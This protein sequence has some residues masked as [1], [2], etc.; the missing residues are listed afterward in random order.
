M[1]FLKQLFCVYFATVTVFP[2]QVWAQV[3]AQPPQAR[4]D[5]QEQKTSPA[6]PNTN[7]APAVAPAA[8][9]APAAKSAVK[10]EAKEGVKAGEKKDE[11]KKP[12]VKKP[13]IVRKD[14]QPL[15][16]A[17]HLAAWKVGAAARTRISS[18]VGLKF[19]EDFAYFQPYSHCQSPF[20]GEV[21]LS[22]VISALGE[23][24]TKF[25][26]FLAEREG[27]LNQQGYPTLGKRAKD[28][29][30]SNGHSCQP[31]FPNSLRLVNDENLPGEL[32]DKL[33]ADVYKAGSDLISPPMKA[34]LEIGDE[35][36]LSNRELLLYTELIDALRHYTGYLLTHA[37]NYFPEEGKLKLPDL[38][39]LTAVG[40]KIHF[41]NAR[42]PGELAYRNYKKGGLNRVRAVHAA[43]FLPRF[44]KCGDL[45]NLCGVSRDSS[46][47]ETSYCFCDSKPET[48]DQMDINILLALQPKDPKSLGKRPHKVYLEGMRKLGIKA[49]M[50]QLA[51]LNPQLPKES[52]FEL[53]QVCRAAPDLK[54]YVT[55]YN[56]LIEVAPREDWISNLKASV[57]DYGQKLRT[58]KIPF[59]IPSPVQFSSFYAKANDVAAI[60]F[61][62]LKAKHRM[63]PAGFAAVDQLMALLPFRDRLKD[64]DPSVGSDLA[65]HFG[66]KMLAWSYLVQSELSRLS[67]DQWNARHK[68]VSDMVREV[69]IYTFSDALYIYVS[70]LARNRLNSE[71]DQDVVLRAFW[72]SHAGL[73]WESYLR[74]QA[75]ENFFDAVDQDGTK[76]NLVQDIADVIL[77]HEAFNQPF[78][79][80]VKANEIAAARSR[81]LL[82]LAESAVVANEAVRYMS[83]HE[84]YQGFAATMLPGI[85][86][87]GVVNPWNWTNYFYAESK[88]KDVTEAPACFQVPDGEGHEGMYAALRLDP[89]RNYDPLTGLASP[90]HTGD[91]VHIKEGLKGI[92]G[93]KERVDSLTKQLEKKGFTNGMVRASFSMKV[94]QADGSIKDIRIE[95][96]NTLSRVIVKKMMETMDADPKKDRGIVQTSRAHAINQLR[97]WYLSNQSGARALYEKS[98]EAL[99]GIV[100]ERNLRAFLETKP[101]KGADEA[102]RK[103]WQAEFEKKLKATINNELIISKMDSDKISDLIA[104][105]DSYSDGEKEIEKLTKAVSEINDT[106]KS[107]LRQ[108]NA[109]D[110][111]EKWAKY[112]LTGEF[113]NSKGD[114]Q[115][116]LAWFDEITTDLLASQYLNY[117]FE[118]KAVKAT[119]DVIKGS[120][121]LPGFATYFGRSKKDSKDE[122]YTMAYEGQKTIDALKKAATPPGLDTLKKVTIDATERFV[123]K[124]KTNHRTVTLDGY[125]DSSVKTDLKKGPWLVITVDGKKNT[126]NPASLRFFLAPEKANNLFLTFWTAEGL[127]DDGK[128]IKGKW[129]DK[130]TAIRQ[131]SLVLPP[132][133]ALPLSPEG[134]KAKN[135]LDAALAAREGILRNAWL[136]EIPNENRLDFL[137]RSYVRRYQALHAQLK[138]VP[139]D[140]ELLA[141]LK[142][143][144]ESL[145][146]AKKNVSEPLKIN[147]NTHH[148]TY[149][150][151]EIKDWEQK[152]DE[153]LIELSKR[154][155]TK[156]NEKLDIPTILAGVDFHA[157]K[158]FKERKVFEMWRTRLNVVK[159]KVV[160]AI[161]SKDEAQITEVFPEVR[162]LFTYLPQYLLIGGRADAASEFTRKQFFPALATLLFP[163]YEEFIVE[164]QNRMAV[165]ELTDVTPHD[166]IK[167][168]NKDISEN[169]LGIW[170][171]EQK[172]YAFIGPLA[173]IEKYNDQ[174]LITEGHKKIAELKKR[175]AEAR[176]LRDTFDQL[177]RIL[178]NYLA[179]LELAQ[180]VREQLAEVVQPELW[181]AYFE[182]QFLYSRTD[183]WNKEP[184]KATVLGTKREVVFTPADV[185][186]DLNAIAKTR[187]PLVPV[188]PKVALEFVDDIDRVCK[189]ATSKPFIEAQSKLF[190]D[191]INKLMLDYY[192]LAAKRHRGTGEEKRLEQLGKRIDAIWSLQS[193]G[194]LASM[195]FQRWFAHTLEQFR[196]G[197]LEKPSLD[198]LKAPTLVEFCQA[199]TGVGATLR[200]RIENEKDAKELSK[201]VAY[202][203]WETLVL[204]ASEVWFGA[205]TELGPIYVFSETDPKKQVV[206]FTHGPVA[207]KTIG[208][209][210]T[211]FRSDEK[212]MSALG[213][214]FGQTGLSTA[215]IDEMLKEQKN[216][217]FKALKDAEAE[218]RVAALN[219]LSVSARGDLFEILKSYLQGILYAQQSRS[220]GGFSTRTK[221]SEGSSDDAFG[222]SGVSDEKDSDEKESADRPKAETEKTPAKAA[223]VKSAD[224]ATVQPKTAVPGPRPANGQAANAQKSATQPAAKPAGKTTG[225]PPQNQ[226]KT[227]AQT[228][229]KAADPKAAAQPAATTEQPGFST[230]VPGIEGSEGEAAPVLSQVP[231]YLTIFP[232]AKVGS[233]SYDSWLA[234][235]ET[236]IKLWND[237]SGT[238]AFLVNYRG[239][240]TSNGLVWLSDAIVTHFILHTSYEIRERRVVIPADDGRFTFGAYG[241]YD[242]PSKER[243]LD[244]FRTYQNAQRA[245]I[246]QDIINIV[247]Y[248]KKRLRDELE[249]LR[250][251]TEKER[252]ALGYKPNKDAKKVKPEEIKPFNVALTEAEDQSGKKTGRK[253]GSYVRFVPIPESKLENSEVALLNF[254]AR[255]FIESEEAFKALGVGASDEIKDDG[256]AVS[257]QEWSDYIAQN[258]FAQKDYYFLHSEESKI[259][260]WQWEPKGFEYEKSVSRP[261]FERWLSSLMA[262]P[263][264]AKIFVA[265]RKEKSIAPRLWDTF[266]SLEKFKNDKLYGQIAML[267]E[268]ADKQLEASKEPN[269]YAYFLA[270]LNWNI[271]RYGVRPDLKIGRQYLVLEEKHTAALM[272]EVVENL[273]LDL[274]HYAGWEWTLKSWGRTQ[275]WK[276]IALSKRNALVAVADRATLATQVEAPYVENP[277][278]GVNYGYRPTPVHPMERMLS[279]PFKSAAEYRQWLSNP[280]VYIQSRVNTDEIDR[281]LYQQMAALKGEMVGEWHL[282]NKNP[283]HRTL[284]KDGGYKF[285]ADGKNVPDARIKE[286]VK[287]AETLHIKASEPELRRV[288][289]IREAWLDFRRKTDELRKK[290]PF[291]S[292]RIAP[293]YHKGVTVPLVGW[294][295]PYVPS[296]SPGRG[297]SIA[298]NLGWAVSFEAIDELSQMLKDY[299][300]AVGGKL[301]PTINWSLWA[302]DY[303]LN[304]LFEANKMAEEAMY[305]GVDRKQTARLLNIIDKFYEEKGM[306][307][308][309][310]KGHRRIGENIVG[311]L[312]NLCKLD[313]SGIET[314]AQLNDAGDRLKK[315][316]LLYMDGLTDMLN[317]AIPEGESN[318][319]YRML[320]DIK[321]RKGPWERAWEHYGAPA[322]QIA[323]MA[324]MAYTIAGKSPVSRL[325]AGGAG[326]TILNIVFASSFMWEVHND[327]EETYG[328]GRDR[329]KMLTKI[330]DTRVTSYI[331]LMSDQTGILLFDDQQAN[332]DARASMKGWV[333]KVWL[334]LTACEMVGINYRNLRGGVDYLLRRNFSE[335]YRSWQYKRMLKE[336]KLTDLEFKDARGVWK[337]ADEMASILA[338]KSEAAFAKAL[339]GH[340]VEGHILLDKDFAAAYEKWIEKKLFF[341][342]HRPEL[343][344]QV[345]QLEDALAQVRSAR[346]YLS[347]DNLIALHANRTGPYVELMPLLLR[348]PLHEDIYHLI[349]MT[350]TKV[351]RMTGIKGLIRPSAMLD[352]AQRVA[353]ADQGLR[354][355][356]VYRRIEAMRESAES[357]FAPMLADLFE[358][359][360]GYDE[361]QRLLAAIINREDELHTR[362]MEYLAAKRGI[363]ELTAGSS[364]V[365]VTEATDIETARRLLLDVEDLIQVWNLGGLPISPNQR[366]F[367]KT[368]RAVARRDYDTV[369]LILSD[370]RKG[371]VEMLP[372]LPTDEA[373]ATKRTWPEWFTSWTGGLK[374]TESGG[375]L[376]VVRPEE[377]VEAVE[378]LAGV[379]MDFTGVCNEALPFSREVQRS[380]L[381]IGDAM[382]Q[383]RAGVL[384]DR[385]NRVLSQRLSSRAI[386]RRMG[387]LQAGG[388]LDAT[389]ERIYRTAYEATRAMEAAHSARRASNFDDS[390]FRDDTVRYFFEGL[391]G[392]T[393]GS[394]LAM[395]EGI[396]YL[397]E[398]ITSLRPY[399][400]ERA[401]E[402]AAQFANPTLV[403]NTAQTIR[404]GLMSDQLGFSTLNFDQLAY[405]LGIPREMLSTDLT[406]RA[407]IRDLQ[408]WSGVSFRC[409][410]T[411]LRQVSDQ[412]KQQLRVLVSPAGVRS[413]A[414]ARALLPTAHGMDH[415]VSAAAIRTTR[416]LDR[417]AGGSVQSHQY[418][419]FRRMKDN[420]DQAEQIL[421]S[422]R[423][424]RAAEPS[425]P[426]APKG[427][428]TPNEYAA[429][430]LAPRPPEPAAPAA[431]EGTAPATSST[432]PPQ[433][434]A[435]GEY[436]APKLRQKPKELPEATPDFSG[437]TSS[438][439]MRD[440]AHNPIIQSY[441]DG[442]H[443]HSPALQMVEGRATLDVIAE[444][445]AEILKEVKNAARVAEITGELR[446][447][448]MLHMCEVLDSLV[449][450]GAIQRESADFSALRDLF[451]QRYVEEGLANS[452]PKVSEADAIL[453]HL[454]DSTQIG[455]LRAL[456]A[457]EESL[458]EGSDALV[459]V[460]VKRSSLIQNELM[461]TADSGLPLPILRSKEIVS[462]PRVLAQLLGS[463]EKATRFIRLYGEKI[464]KNHVS[465]E[466]AVQLARFLTDEQLILEAVNAKW[467]ADG[468]RPLEALAKEMEAERMALKRGQFRL[469]TQFGFDRIPAPPDEQFYE[470]PEVGDAPGIPGDGTPPPPSDIP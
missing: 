144:K 282:V 98:A 450:T 166:A 4:P 96:T 363:E 170:K 208:R 370:P 261:E 183:E 278:W 63:G 112:C 391:V 249:E 410:G 68:I 420:V 130:G 97:N 118:T 298:N 50:V 73:E 284:M 179:G 265:K 44:V 64:G 187:V 172:Q 24:Q 47:P 10:P 57:G 456:Q 340:A 13:K 104:A 173:S 238:P 437:G 214:F 324:L 38:V 414:E 281:A 252:I 114:E 18:I 337:S 444:K 462:R 318:E 33:L 21:N 191:S 120:R 293:E 233:A 413:V 100:F 70:N 202:S 454:M 49:A 188:Q 448:R 109:L 467:H 445:Q 156:K 168:I 355:I 29:V 336:L 41:L 36:D 435:P 134:S 458:E 266:E 468:K 236:Y 304:A 163:P 28:E 303:A 407:I 289:Q 84:A 185:I 160:A 423:P 296:L 129:A 74:S 102:T 348:M 90:V 398:E 69:L 349:T 147:A 158:Q 309:Y 405:V 59:P 357:S 367:E 127:G 417:L 460:W 27:E 466:E 150:F 342:R 251:T 195:G 389:S 82:P 12:E 333:Y 310:Q 364:T 7:V 439:K 115:D 199:I 325:S 3:Q 216:Q 154:L 394:S 43:E 122:D 338:R 302:E 75:F 382:I 110:S 262:D 213:E 307:L 111:A 206:W 247:D 379:A 362:V 137:V 223:A 119:G 16:E 71:V 406:W 308:E 415:E 65:S 424:P 403:Q 230:V 409:L 396:I 356:L 438:L 380:Y 61:D 322:M 184:L 14:R 167:A 390:I 32:T 17:F 319:T 470:I 427:P 421:K 250:T 290:Y 131:V 87:T 411:D 469:Q 264:T 455:N 228:A 217:T 89:N 221:S 103:A 295:I 180:K 46:S 88:I 375:A 430:K 77:K 425:G 51:A 248:E 19:N 314:D 344:E 190:Q 159:D 105:Y 436:A 360:T 378:P 275:D 433:E 125:Y 277:D 9:V 365:V 416:E 1:G 30:V 123:E 107:P 383:Q 272:Q 192:R 31:Y 83:N 215:A 294:K 343:G 117:Y 395:D 66:E 463:E 182:D 67:P 299:S 255:Y 227:V 345:A 200:P 330:R 240:D 286:L 72:D 449:E 242:R 359:R 369:G 388:Q 270:L 211:T 328:W 312:E 86:Y 400:L 157:K 181:Q 133:G 2:P 353:R 85:P 135:K 350:S 198:N 175:R 194:E 446:Q 271:N 408:E 418:G 108:N 218:K 231:A 141:D 301:D 285:G 76:Q 346:P 145:A 52:R 226:P 254:Y 201:P 260:R 317:Q 62:E 15:R 177:D 93:R 306:T 431:A 305:K 60:Y 259:F 95:D 267:M 203:Y 11:V 124:E 352:R 143:S 79:A 178:A 280:S 56:D 385:V 219:G 232:K 45:Q 366:E 54:D 300:E 39:L 116:C 283:N 246:V 80:D 459:A 164:L 162:Y 237:L 371:V 332:I 101:A 152:V 297:D 138:R 244:E 258:D 397:G 361:M 20:K 193:D 373:Q 426:T 387:I 53:P 347:R 257:L 222:G 209:K 128:W 165:V 335:R 313:V 5:V 311:R 279:M 121:E 149:E 334:A 457:L 441:V 327:L 386:A 224:K 269:T 372:F 461:G 153:F 292:M 323:F 384:T 451:M 234:Q 40:E 320:V 464:A 442:S 465:E 106:E 8:Q 287:R 92:V 434:L 140:E 288:I 94:K 239:H 23:A 210:S 368:I 113:K 6:T 291:E 321:T 392:K 429:P 404:D 42:N 142:I 35:E 453:R 189:T 443:L 146:E 315:A 151:A 171:L 91:Y 276:A 126:V 428:S 81:E 161:R 243:S 34:L 22:E 316:E 235:L 139:T 381:Q 402:R 169:Q 399:D 274:K 25:S 229:T 241:G 273:G 393:N 263:E 432:L 197:N 374:R 220:F 55:L 358:G 48:V 419:L 132:G 339:E 186:N 268:L 212:I 174:K 351:G 331:N 99:A 176:K 422:G 253:T 412:L 37:Q 354:Q 136:G 225:T 58:G 26:K 204:P 245:T 329:L 256:K 205:K 207:A 326:S 440:R 148:W 196:E 155:R 377:A 78:D 447:L 401:V 376:I 452:I 341:I